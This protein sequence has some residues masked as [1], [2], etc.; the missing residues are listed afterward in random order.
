MTHPLLYLR[1]IPP[2]SANMAAAVL[3]WYDN[4]VD[5]SNYT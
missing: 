4:E 3:V 1:L 5:A 2:S